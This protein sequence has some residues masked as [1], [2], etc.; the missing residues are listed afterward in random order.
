MGC[1]QEKYGRRQ[2]KRGKS[3]E[4]CK[5]SVAIRGM[6]KGLATHSFIHLASKEL[7]YFL[8]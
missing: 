1:M 3:M 6:E 8:I 7:V 4:R 5:K 2:A